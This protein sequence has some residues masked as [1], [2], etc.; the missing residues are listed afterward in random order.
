[1]ARTAKRYLMN[2]SKE[3]PLRKKYNVGNYLR[4]S[5]DSDYTGSD[6]L[7]NQRRLAQ[8]YIAQ[9]EGIHLVKEYID[10]GRSGTNFE[11]P[12]FIRMITDLKRG[13]INC[14]IVKDLSRFGREY[15]EA[16]NY[17]E[18]VFPFLGVRFISILD[19]YDSINPHC[20]RELLLIS[21]KN[22]MHEMYAKDVSK[23]VGSTFKIKHEKGI[24][25]RSTTI[26]YGYRMN[27]TSTNYSIDE[28]TAEIVR[29]MFSQYGSG[30]S[31]G[32]IRRY[33]YE[34]K[35]LTPRQYGE[36]GQVYGVDEGETK[37]WEISTI[38]RILKNPVYIGT[39]IRH[40]S[41]QSF[42]D[43]QSHIMIPEDEWVT[44]RNNH[45]QLISEELF[46]KVQ[47]LLEETKATYASYRVDSNQVKE[48]ASYESN[49]FQGKLFCGD[50]KANMI[51]TVKY[52]TVQGEQVRY[53]NF[54]CDAHRKIT[55]L[56]DAKSI[57]EAA[58]CEILYNTVYN[59]IKLIKNIKK[60]IERDI[61]Y[62]FDD[63]MQQI[64][65]ERSR[66]ENA[67]A[68]LEREYMEVYCSYTNQT[69]PIESF[70]N[71]RAKYSEKID[72]LKSQ[73]LMLEKEETNVKKCKRAMNR[74]IT[75]W[76][77]FDNS[78][79]LT[80]GMIETCIS[81]IELFSNNRLE[82][83]LRYQ[84]CFALLEDWMKRGGKAL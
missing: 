49:V 66:I 6:S 46:N 40:K 57:E 84:D 75:E 59:H 31:K 70:N 12:A 26:P 78:S 55:A 45:E 7:E 76:L 83:T 53:K 64:E 4:L 5:V 52:L 41:K 79:K 8:E 30:A 16:G 71:F 13:I 23:K 24:F 60:I 72:L 48:S 32:A 15:I 44:I 82:V 20:D 28:P 36:K 10:D 65:H 68:L 11:R 58:L 39:I 80:E 34:N 38:D 29:E 51:R 3:E 61:K 73:M 37:A 33:L 22:L 69:L 50:C 74:L 27:G 1:M 25:Y 43:D 35:V 9:A 81:R 54:V 21:L 2:T 67:M 19:R 14:I 47:R 18:K 42:F 62:S 77:V 17:I 56:C 63:K